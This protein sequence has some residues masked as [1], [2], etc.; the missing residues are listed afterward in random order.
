[1]GNPN[2]TKIREASIMITAILPALF[3]D[4]TMC[5]AGVLISGCAC[6]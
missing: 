2:L 1:M 4:E 3:A 5:V 6:G